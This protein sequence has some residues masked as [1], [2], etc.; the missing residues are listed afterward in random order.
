M[1]GRACLT[2]VGG[3]CIKF[4]V[5][6]RTHHSVEPGDPDPYL[7][8]TVL[9]ACHLL[10]AF[11]LDGEMLRLRDLVSRTGLNKTTAFRLLRSLE[12]GGII[13]HTTTG[14]YR[15]TIRSLH[16]RK[17][18]L[19]YA[20]QSTC[21][22]FSREITNGLLQAADHEG[23][24]ILALD[25]RGSRKITLQ[26]AEKLIKHR[27]DLAIE[28]QQH[29]QIAPILSAKFHEACIPLI[30]ISFPHPGAVYYGANN[31]QAGV[32]AGRALGQWAKQHF[33]GAVDE[34]ILLGRA[35]SGPWLQSRLKGVEM[36]IREVLTAAQHARLVQLSADGQFQRSF[37]VIH[38]HLR[39][40]S[41][42]RILLGAI[43]DASALGALCAFHELGRTLN[44]GIVSH[45]ASTEGRAEL[46]NPETRL[47][48]SVG[49]FPEKYGQEVIALALKILN[50]KPVSPAVFVHHCLITP[51]NV[52]Q[53][54]CQDV[55]TNSV[56]A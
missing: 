44:C 21:S 28:H 49:F 48:G 33:Q 18:R 53:F 20:C 8:E 37:E 22:A 56:N 55:I 27:V 4:H 16:R 45:G 6:K 11:T 9:R 41:S 42:T 7:S 43:N 46:R 34:I 47:V 54:Y 3:S 50:K 30:A 10:R 13:E 51:A 40:T 35:L 26:N 5:V 1:P 17:I 38:K 39:Y 2:E 32:I 31:Y 52:D 24:D 25:N 12:K 19:G 36:G 29:D 23:I 14:Q 15:T